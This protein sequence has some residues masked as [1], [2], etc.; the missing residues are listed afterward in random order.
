M[1]NRRRFMMT[2]AGSALALPM[3]GRTGLVAAQSDD[4]SAIAGGAGS[5]ATVTTLD[6][7]PYATVTLD[8]F[9]AEWNDTN[10]EPSVYGGYRTMVAD[11]TI[12]AIGDER[13]TINLQDFSLTSTQGF[14]NTTSITEGLEETTYERLDDTKTFLDSGESIQYSLVFAANT[15]QEYGRLYWKP[16]DAGIMSFDITEDVDDPGELEPSLAP[17]GETTTTVFTPEGEEGAA[18]SF[19]SIEPIDGPDITIDGIEDPEF[20]SLKSTIENLQD[21]PLEI[22]PQSFMVRDRNGITH[23]GMPIDPET[24]EVDYVLKIEL[25][26]GD[27]ADLEVIVVGESG[28]EPLEFFFN[29]SLGDGRMGWATIDIAGSGGASPEASPES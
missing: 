7:A 2:M 18:L 1:M 4:A 21:I 14:W 8:S 12:E 27:T 22:D 25:D 6:G 13:V 20:M 23:G 19:I 17:A 5:T 29:H 28:F 16:E 26:P 10:G 15:I 11:V 24:F 3:I 9:H